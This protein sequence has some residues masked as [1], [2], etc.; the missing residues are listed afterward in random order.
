MKHCIATRAYD[1]VRGNAYLFHVEHK[2]Q[3]ASV[4]VSPYSGNVVQAAGPGN[5][6]NQAAKWATRV[7]N[8]WGRGLVATRDAGVQ[9]G[10]VQEHAAAGCI[11]EAVPF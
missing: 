10:L 4:E 11:G 2:G 7:L 3:S 8:R 9:V 5:E 6:L 1:A